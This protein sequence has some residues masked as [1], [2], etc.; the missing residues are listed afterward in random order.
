MLEPMA[1]PVFRVIAKKMDG[2]NRQSGPGLANPVGRH[3]HAGRVLS[4]G[5]DVLE[6]PLVQRFKLKQV[7][8]LGIP[9][10][11]LLKQCKQF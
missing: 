11:S 2:I 5:P 4:R 3:E 8:T 10:L 7:P 6:L 1:F 9:A